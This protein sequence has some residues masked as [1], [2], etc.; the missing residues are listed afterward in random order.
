[1]LLVL[2]EGIGGSAFGRRHAVELV[3]RGVVET[4]L[5]V[6]AQTCKVDTMTQQ[7][8]DTTSLAIAKDTQHEMLGLDERAMETVGFLLAESQYLLN[9]R[10]EFVCHYRCQ[11]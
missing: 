11:K 8:L 9:A 10:V 1:M 6:H 7:S 2:V 4:L 5:D 3:T